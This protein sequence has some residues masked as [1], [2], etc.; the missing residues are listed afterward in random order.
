M[1]IEEFTV[2]LKPDCR[3][4]NTMIGERKSTAAAAAALNIPVFPPPTA[5]VPAPVSHAANLNGRHAHVYLAQRSSGGKR[6]FTFFNYLAV[7]C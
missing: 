1:Q 7:I 6:E 2:Q 3:R 5:H 4:A